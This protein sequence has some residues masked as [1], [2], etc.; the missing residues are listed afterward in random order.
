MRRSSI[1]V[2]ER[3]ARLLGDLGHAAEQLGVR[4]RRLE[5][6][7]AE[8][9]RHA[10]VLVLRRLVD[11]HRIEAGLGRDRWRRS[12]RRRTPRPSTSTS[13][14][15]SDGPV[16]MP[17]QD[18]CPCRARA[19]RGSGTRSDAAPRA[20][21]PTARCRPPPPANRASGSA[22]P[23]ERRHDAPH[24][25]VDGASTL[26]SGPMADLRRAKSASLASAAGAPLSERRAPLREARR[27]ARR[28]SPAL[29]P[30]P[31]R[32]WRCC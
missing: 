21:R 13:S 7:E 12:G 11:E 32:R 5:L 3:R 24:Q 4:R 31:W 16:S 22:P 8:D 25:R 28:P 15:C 10:A 27:S 20:S 2:D 29:R 14:T 30:R 9:Q 23:H 6:V 26:T 19:P 1:A 17:A 18:A